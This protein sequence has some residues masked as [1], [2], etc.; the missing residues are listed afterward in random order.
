[1]NE[2][3]HYLRELLDQRSDSFTAS[4]ASFGVPLALV[5]TG[6]LKLFPLKW[7]YISP[8]AFINGSQTRSNELYLKFLDELTRNDA[9]V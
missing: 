6:G 4:L 7:F 5:G 9:L 2:I 8:S 3:H 1:M